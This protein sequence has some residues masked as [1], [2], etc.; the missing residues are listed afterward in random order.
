MAGK[1]RQSSIRKRQARALRAFPMILAIFLA[2]PA[3][4]QP[5][6]DRL[7]FGLLYGA[8]NITVPAQ[9]IYVRLWSEGGRIH[10]R[11]VPDNKIHEISGSLIATGKG[12]FKDTAPLSE[13]LRIRQQRPSRIDFDGTSHTELNG[14][15]V[16]L[17]GDFQSLIVDIKVDGRQLP[18]RLRIG[19]DQDSPN[20]LPVEFGLGGADETWLDRFGF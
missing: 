18:K 11:F 9:E 4:A 8:P 3:G 7:P 2:I 5:R 14:L 19:T 20:K 15:D 1:R 16:I 6:L 12:V 17:A 10:L 13:E